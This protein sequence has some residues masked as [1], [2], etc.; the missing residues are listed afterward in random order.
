MAQYRVLVATNLWPDETDPGYGAFVKEQMESLRPLGVEYDVLY[1]HGRESRWNYLRP[2]SRC[3]G[4]SGR[5]AT[6]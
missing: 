2:F 5:N 1:I 3:G 6:I 4:G